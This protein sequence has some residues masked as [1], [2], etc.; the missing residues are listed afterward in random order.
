MS[1]N[2]VLDVIQNKNGK[3]K[4]ILPEARI[5]TDPQ[6]KDVSQAPYDTQE[7]SGYKWAP[8][9]RNDRL[10]TE[11]R[12]KIEKVPMAGVAVYK[13]TAMMYGNGLAYFKNS[14]LLNGNTDVKRA[15]IPEIETWL[16]QN[17]LKTKW[18]I[19]QLV[20][21]RYNMNT[22]SEMILNRKMDFITGLY[23]HTSEFCRLD[24]QN[25]STLDINNLNYS[26]K[27]GAFNVPGE[28]DI[29][30]I[31]L[32]RWYDEARFLEKLRSYNFAWHSHLRTPGTTYYARPFWIGLFQKNGWIDASI[33]VPKIVNAMMSNQIRLKYQILIPESYFQIRHQDWD[34]YTDAERN[35][36]ID[37][38]INYINDNLGSTDNAYA[39]IST[40]FKTD[41]ITGN[42]L[43]KV[44]IVSIDDHVKEGSWVPSANAAD[45]QIVQGLGLHP[46]QVGLAPEGGKMGAGSGSDQRESFNTGISLN[47]IDQE[48]VLEP[49]NYVAQFNSR[50]NPSWDVTFFVDHTSHTTTNK[51]ES[52]L[53][54]SD[55]SIKIEE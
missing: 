34:S 42:A 25:E 16:K 52:G 4:A 18:F 1:K 27:F 7:T 55:T 47:T 11:I 50:V 33:S 14:D 38:L 19:P 20:D 3:L 24:V 41:P 37:T 30:R 12:Q 9:G 53:Q 35:A 40:I 26:P 10:P 15:Y 17:M 45:A 21:Y 32:F 51:Q 5:T 54:P 31:P 6:K 13:L 29:K 39:S 28:A 2:I 43:G 44:E 8:W 46:S 48:I 36:K 23:H 49:L 22:F